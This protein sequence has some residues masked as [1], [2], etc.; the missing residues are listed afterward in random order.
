MNFRYQIFEVRCFSG[1][2]N[3]G[4]IVGSVS[5]SHIV[6][7]GRLPCTQRNVVFQFCDVTDPDLRSIIDSPSSVIQNDQPCCPRDGWYRSDC[8][9]KLL[10]M[11]KLKWKPFVK[12]YPLRAGGGSLRLAGQPSKLGQLAANQPPL[13]EKQTLSYT[14]NESDSSYSIFEDDEDDLDEDC[15]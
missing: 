1:S 15:F 7:A 13:E 11:I 3:D 8:K 12:E 5:D 4:G 14:L 2:S 6:E 9:P 10:A